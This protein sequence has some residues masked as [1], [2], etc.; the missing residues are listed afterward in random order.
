[1]H[2]V[3]GGGRGRDLNRSE[4]AHS[5]EVLTPDSNNC[6]DDDENCMCASWEYPEPPPEDR[7]RT[8]FSPPGPS[9]GVPSAGTGE[10]LICILQSSCSW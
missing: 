2:A 6:A 10:H 4:E 1:M 7:V 5:P 8:V 9:I 3:R